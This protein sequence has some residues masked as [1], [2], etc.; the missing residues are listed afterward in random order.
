MH[1]STVNEEK[2]REI[3]GNAEEFNPVTEG[4]FSYAQV[5]YYFTQ[6]YFCFYLY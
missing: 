2:V 6:S 5:A 3:H 1:E 4:M